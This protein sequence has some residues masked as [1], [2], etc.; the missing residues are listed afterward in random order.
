MYTRPEVDGPEVV[1]HGTD[2]AAVTYGLCILP[3][4][5]AGAEISDDACRGREIGMR[6]HLDTM[7]PCKDAHVT[8]TSYK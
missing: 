4:D 7:L 3:D 5:V 1:G 6:Q 2:T 8:D